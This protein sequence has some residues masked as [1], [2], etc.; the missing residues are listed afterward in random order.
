[1]PKAIS[2]WSC[3][4]TGPGVETCK[5]RYR[6]KATH[7]NFNRSSEV[8]RIRNELKKMKVSKQRL[9]IKV[10]RKPYK[11]KSY[12]KKRTNQKLVKKLKALKK[13]RAKREAKIKAPKVAVTKKA[14]NDELDELARFNESDKVDD[15]MVKSD[16]DKSLS[17]GL[18]D[19]LEE[20]LE[21]LNDDVEEKTSKLQSDDDSDES[22][23]DVEVSN[24]E[25]KSP[26]TSDPAKLAAF[27]LEMIQIA[28]DFDSL[29]TL[30]ASWTPRKSF[31]SKIGMRGQFGLK[32]IKIFSGTA[33]EETFLVYELGMYLMLNFN[34]NLFAEVGYVLQKWN[35]TA[36]DSVSAFSV[37]GGYIFSN[38]VMGVFDRVF[39]DY[40][41]VS[42]DT[43]NREL[44]FS[45][46]LSF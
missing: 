44:K 17:E 46:G 35:N 2:T 23:E 33:F 30:G 14:M 5:L 28:D 9:K 31:N 4:K 29:V 36:G 39:I 37:G 27:S 13:A 10:S 21:D 45:L 18:E 40:S 24:D 20:E 41:T 34:A 3:K 6:C 19:D 42:N 15:A 16:L 12:R 26:Y 43:A 25:D 1:M 22:D 32:S 11:R 38:P 8:G 7:R